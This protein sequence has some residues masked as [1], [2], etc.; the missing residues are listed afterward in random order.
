MAA[1]AQ[2]RTG[3]ANVLTHYYDEL[4]QIM[5]SVRAGRAPLP[6]AGAGFAPDFALPPLTSRLERYFS[7][8]S[9]TTGDLGEYRGV[10][11]S[12]LNLMGNPGTRTTKTLASLLMVARAV[13]HIQRTGENVMIVTPSSANKATALRDAVLG[14]IRSG[15]VTPD[16]L[17]IAV[18]VPEASRPK[19]WSSPLST[20]P[21]LAA[22]NPVLVLPG[23][24]RS[25]VKTLAAGLVEQHADTVYALTGTRLWYSLDLDNYR[26][27]DAA[28]ALYERDFC[29][30]R[31]GER[32]LHAHAVSSAYG[33]L[34]HHLGH[35]AIGADGDPR[36]FLVQHLD[37]PDMV[38]NL[39]F[40][41]AER[42]HLP[43]YRYD[44][45]DGLYRQD[46]DLRFP[47]TTY[48]PDEI[49]D[50]TFYTHRPPTSARMNELIRTGGGGGIV[51]SL[52]ECLQRYP[53]L[54]SRLGEAGVHLPA[55]P[56]RLREWSLV[57]AATG[58]LNA[59]DRGLISDDE[60][61]L[62]GSGSYGLDD[63]VPLRD[64]AAR[65]VEQACDL[66]K[67][68]FHAVLV[69]DGD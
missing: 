7:A 4:G 42:D 55:D 49:L 28:R 3:S 24:D 48:H 12:L 27:A 63:Y 13:G 51:V 33:L 57:M 54:R 37:T 44:A 18:V 35:T 1:V 41:S 45:A 20:D 8:G 29:P 46:G 47:V 40:G 65:T 15:L 39:Y 5:G 9:I 64:D 17:R 38:L 36:Y 67:A 66:R 68:V 32:R 16:Q 26:T 53:L 56:R 62:H 59:I 14:A 22:R 2:P 11:L 21:E 23:A 10:R 61:L 6:T 31:P 30:A 52:H 69:G 43:A 50:P 25:A 34:G 58:V 60:V 19:L